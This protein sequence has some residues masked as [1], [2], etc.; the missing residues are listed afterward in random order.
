MKIKTILIENFKGFK[1]RF[2]L[3]LNEGLN[4]LVGDNE[5]G[6]STI[7][8]AIHLALSGLYHGK[9]F[10]TDFNQYLFNNEVL[11]EYI[12]GLF[13]TS[14]LPPPQIIIEIYFD[15]Q[16]LPEL[17]GDGHSQNTS[18]NHCGFTFK[19]SFDDKY[20]SEY[21]TLVGLGEIKSLPIEYYKFTWNSFAREQITPKLIPIK[22][23]LID[24]SSSRFKNGSDI[25]IKNC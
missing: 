14:P 13:T 17:E 16:N 23:A 15:A 10:K 12:K 1:G 21:E 24:S 11:S 9:F 3:E 25:Y 8:E 22:S 7:L 20:K 2:T 5:A 4:I 18:T 19:I 6:K